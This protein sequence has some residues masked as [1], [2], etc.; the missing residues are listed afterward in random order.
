MGS[1]FGDLFTWWCPKWSPPSVYKVRIDAEKEERPTRTRTA[2]RKPK[3]SH[4]ETA[5]PLK[6]YHNWTC[7]KKWPF[8]SFFH[9]FLVCRFSPFNWET[10]TLFADGYRAEFCFHARFAPE[11]WAPIFRCGGMWGSSSD[12]GCVPWM[13]LTAI[14][15]TFAQFLIFFPPFF[16][17]EKSPISPLTLFFGAYYKLHMG[18]VCVAWSLLFTV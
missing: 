14:I 6:Y 11:H 2:L 18:E 15:A 1:L 8:L 12:A 5:I 10:R 16:P 4:F 13:P 9:R 3:F 7:S 17:D